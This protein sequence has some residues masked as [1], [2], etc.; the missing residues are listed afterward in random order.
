MISFIFFIFIILIIFYILFFF[1][2]NKKI[3]VVQT[4]NNKEYCKK[5]LEIAINKN[6]DEIYFI[7]NADN[8]N[9]TSNY[10]K[11]YNLKRENIGRDYGAYLFFIVHFYNKIKILKEYF[12]YEQYIVFSSANLKKHNRI[13][14]FNKFINKTNEFKGC[15]KIKSVKNFCISEYEGDK[16]KLASIRPLYKWYNKF[17]GDF[18]KIENYPVCRRGIL[19]GTSNIV[20]TP[21][22]LYVNLYN[23]CNNNNHEVVHYLERIFYPLINYK[24]L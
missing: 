19:N 7:H 6:Y 14:L 23:Q 13:E 2:K 10:K 15:K 12:N 20:K 4:Y 11:I 9:I 21:K 18:E 22:P 8:L 16:L 17:I 3:L 5:L 1:K 24:G